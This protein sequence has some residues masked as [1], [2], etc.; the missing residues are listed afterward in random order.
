[1]AAIPTYDQRTSVSGAGLGPGPDQPPS[2]GVGE[3]LQDVGSGIQSVVK[4]IDVV[5]ER[6][7]ATWSADALS[8]VQSNWLQQL[9]DWKLK[10]APGA[11]DFTPSFLKEFDSAANE[12][13]M[14]A[15]TRAS[16]QFMKERLLA[17]REELQRNAM[18]FEAVSR[19]QNNQDIAQ[20]SVESAGNEILNNPPIFATRLAE[21][22]ALIDAM[23]LTA[24]DKQK[25]NDYAQDAL[26]KYAVIG[27][28]NADPYGMMQEI[29]SANPT[30]AAVR[31]LAPDERLKL[32]DHADSVLRSQI[33][34]AS[35]LEALSERAQKKLADDAAK[36]GDKLLANGHL[37]AGWI[38]SQ[39]AVL[40]AADYRY[41]YGKLTGGDEGSAPRNVPLYA[42]LR[43]RA[44]RGEDVRTDAR[45][46]VQ[47]G[48]IRVADYDRLV[49]EVESEH[50]GWYKSGAEYITSMSGASLLNPD[51]AAPQLKAAMLDQWGDWS[52]LHPQANFREAQSAYQDIVSHNM[53][54]QR[55][56][57]PLPRLLVGGRF[58]PDLIAS[59]NA[60]MKA[61]NSGEM[62]D[63]D[64]AR[65]MEVLL[66]WKRSLEAEKSQVAPK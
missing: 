31:A 57:L 27:H 52:R 53:L 32:L 23:P 59:T 9:E 55:A 50:P 28:I 4:A 51:P 14:A 7:A 3:G 33:A 43:D 24:N 61:H 2:S 36:T 13:A 16:K 58:A 48:A 56:G 38:E 18:S 54:V 1:M 11:P 20:K 10:A 22:K 49:T 12:T 47:R 41:F 6:D 65:E 46:A 29:A 21:R 17:M 60:T 30:N 62:N 64:Y 40:D 34:D 19:V 5:K 26:A 42:D 8:K 66:R 63:A 44:G 37:S 39:R 35:R 45:A 15:P 25:L